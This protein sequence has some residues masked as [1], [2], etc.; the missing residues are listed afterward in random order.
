MGNEAVVSQDA[1]ASGWHRGCSGRAQKTGPGSVASTGPQIRPQGRSETRV[2]TIVAAPGP[3]SAACGLASAAR[4]AGA[5]LPSAACGL[6]SAARAAGAC[7]PSAACGLASAARAAGA[8]AQCGPSLLAQS[9]PAV[10]LSHVAGE[11]APPDVGRADAQLAQPGREPLLVPRGRLQHPQRPRERCP[12][13]LIRRQERDHRIDLP[14]PDQLPKVGDET[15]PGDSRTRIE[16][17]L[18]R[19]CGGAARRADR[20]TSATRPT[21]ARSPG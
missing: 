2:S 10:N 9:E 19:G 16:Q 14:R 20:R 13:R 5:C 1:T 21:A 12:D 8:P 3:R 11:A 6:A 17:E 15:G 18:P 4:A 7:L